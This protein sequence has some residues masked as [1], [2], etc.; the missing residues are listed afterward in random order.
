MASRINKE[1]KNNPIKRLGEIYDDIY[2]DEI[3]DLIGWDYELI[4]KLSKQKNINITCVGDFR[5]TIYSTAVT[6]KKPKTNEEK[7]ERFK[8]FGFKIK[9]RNISWRC[10]QAI[11]DFSNTINI[12]DEYLPTNS[13]IKTI[14]PK[15]EDH[16]GVFAVRK[17]DFHNYV[18]QFNPTI[19]RHSKKSGLKICRGHHAVNF[20]ESK[21][22]TYDR[23]IIIPTKKHLDFIKGSTSAFDKD[24]TDDARN[25]FYVAVTRA[26]YSVA[27]LFDG[28]I[29]SNFIKIWQNNE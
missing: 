4:K 27:F 1:T 23:I 11:C 19:L 15:F 21:G 12:N 8:S 29:E 13:K 20:G 17:N 9:N 2:I 7:L 6:I 28:H 22:L 25:R 26:R 16:L 10:I 18:N 3:Q 14:P 5:Q 24:K